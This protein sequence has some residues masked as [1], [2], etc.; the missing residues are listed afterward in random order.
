MFKAVEIKKNFFWVGVIDWN[1]RDFHGY[2]TV[3]G[4][5]YNSYLLIDEK[6]VLFDT[7][8]TGFEEELLSRISSVIS[9]EEI[10]YLVINHIE[11]D[12]SGGF[13][14][15]IETIKPEKIFLTK[16]GK[17][18][19]EAHLHQ[20]DFP[21]E[22]VKTGMEVKTGANTLQFIETPMIHWPDSMIT[23]IPEMKIL[24]SQDA[25]GQHF[26]TLERFD[27]EVDACILQQETA[28]YYAN[29]VLPYS[30]QVQRLLKTLKEKEISPE[31]ICPDHG[32][33]WRKKVKE[34]LNLYEKWSS[35]KAD[36]KV[37][38]IYDTMWKSTEKMAKAI[39]EG[40]LAE[41]VEAK[42]FRVNL[43]DWTELMAEIMEAKG[44]ILGSSTLNNNMLP[45]MAGFTTYMKGLKPRKKIGAAFGSFGWSGE[46]VK[47]LSQILEEMGTELVHQGLKVK[48]VPNAKALEDCKELGKLVA[49]KVKEAGDLS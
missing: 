27:D 2:N 18:G 6:K 46:A 20:A 14:K 1:I 41:G 17:L 47:Y 43:S 36:L 10:D 23:Y 7:V 4:S 49:K 42:L 11:P 30:P 21:F 45:T 12:H 29:I 35:Y 31:I 32:V 13:L 34:V 39:T 44:L 15:I 9:P 37:L 22:I 8:K 3:R 19:L 24:V 26:A 33:I 40:V 5:S 38:I 28:K 16:N 48:Y 25:F